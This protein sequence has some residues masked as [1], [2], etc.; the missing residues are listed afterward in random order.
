ME[1]TS[2]NMRNYKSV[3]DNADELSGIL[4]HEIAHVELRHGLQTVVSQAGL[5][6]IF[7]LLTGDVSV[8]SSLVFVLPTFL[9][10]A[11]YSRKFETISVF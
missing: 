3:T 4:L 11:S 7:L 5:A 10:E 9:L 1:K 8:A 6:A 2:K